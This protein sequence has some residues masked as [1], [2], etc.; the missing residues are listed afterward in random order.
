MI[1]QRH[2]G[3]HHR[4]IGRLDRLEASEPLATVG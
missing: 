4:Y 3:G 1:E 2:R